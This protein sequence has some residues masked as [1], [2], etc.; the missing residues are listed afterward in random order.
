MHTAKGSDVHPGILWSPPLFVPGMKKFVVPRGRIHALAFL[1]FPL[2][3]VVGVGY[4]ISRYS[5]I[6][7][8]FSERMW[9]NVYCQ[10][11]GYMSYY[12]LVSIS[13]ASGEG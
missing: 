4:C 12:P 10:R 5:L 1:G 8:A 6:S 3:L 7:A 13:F 2:V 9:D 11:G